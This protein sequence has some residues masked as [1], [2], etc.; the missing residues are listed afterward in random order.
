LNVE[1]SIGNQNDASRRDRLGSRSDT[2]WQPVLLKLHALRRF[3]RFRFLCQR[4]LRLID[5]LF[6]RGLVGNSQIGE[7]L[8]VEADACCFK[9]LRKPAV[10]HA[11]GASSGI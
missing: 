5:N 8:A 10:R 3:F 11:V 6:E 2:G 4:V 7:N 1:R 9:S